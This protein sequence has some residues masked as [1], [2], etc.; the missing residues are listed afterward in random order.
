MRPSGIHSGGLVSCTQN[1]SR[2]QVGLFS[3]PM[4][5]SSNKAYTKVSLHSV[6]G[7]LGVRA[8]IVEMN[9]EG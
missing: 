8:E 5:L 3:H 4:L 7:V 1:N 2:V 6:F 9:P